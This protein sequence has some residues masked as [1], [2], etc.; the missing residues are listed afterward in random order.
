MM[1]MEITSFNAKPLCTVIMTDVSKI[2]KK[3]N[4]I[5]NGLRENYILIEHCLCLKSR[6]IG[7]NNET[8][9]RQSAGEM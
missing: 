4:W 2:S 3:Q 8:L 9:I 7:H 6:R 5:V 1:N